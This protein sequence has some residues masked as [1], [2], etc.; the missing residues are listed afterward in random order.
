MCFLNK[1]EI[2]LT[3]IEYHALEIIFDH[4]ISYNEVDI[5]KI[6]NFIKEHLQKKEKIFI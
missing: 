1:V 6:N 2:I 3:S 4:P 5:P